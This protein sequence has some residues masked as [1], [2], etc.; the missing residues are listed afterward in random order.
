MIGAFLASCASGI[1]AAQ[2]KPADTM[3]ILREKARTDKKL[4]VA[5]ALALTEGEAKAF[6]PVYNAYQSDMITH[7]DR[8]LKLID[9][10]SKTYGAMNDETATQLLGEFLWLQNNHVAILT[11]YAPQFQRVLPPV[12]VARLYQIENKMRALVDYELA[13]Q[14]PLIK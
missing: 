7:Y 3:E 14:I 12:K 2:D 4:V 8:V 11:S 10:F 13:R 9:T 6:W 1:A 5:T